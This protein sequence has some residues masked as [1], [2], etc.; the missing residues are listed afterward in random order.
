M[1]EKKLAKYKE[2][3]IKA[4]A[5]IL[6]ELETE[7][8]YFVYNEQGDI[9]DLADTQTSNNLLNTLSDLD[10]EKLKDI[11]IALEKIDEGKYGI[12]EGTGKKIPGARLNHIPWARYSIEYAERV[13]RERRMSSPSE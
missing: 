7:R 5:S 3:L 8:E 10:R 2:M 11:I 4:K 9:V 6:R 13:E 12:C 1:V